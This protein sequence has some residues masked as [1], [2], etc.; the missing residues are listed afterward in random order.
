MIVKNDRYGVQYEEQLE[1]YL[2]ETQPSH[3]SLNERSRIDCLSP[4][5]SKP[6]LSPSPCKPLL[7]SFATNTPHRLHFL[8]THLLHLLLLLQRH[9]VLVSAFPRVRTRVLVTHRVSTLTRNLIEGSQQLVQSPIVPSSPSQNN[10]NATPFLERQTECTRSRRTGCS[11]SLCPCS[12][13]PSPQNPPKRKP[14][15]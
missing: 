11:A 4:S 15:W 2:C 14:G 12:A 3:D 9:L 7:P 10:T 6:L 5:P 1:S 13:T 8:H